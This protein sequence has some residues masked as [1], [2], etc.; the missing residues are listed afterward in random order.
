[1]E[2]SGLECSPKGVSAP[3]GRWR[4]SMLVFYYETTV[5]RPE[6]RV[7][8]EGAV[9]LVWDDAGW[10]L[11]RA[12]CV[13]WHGFRHD[14]TQGWLAPQA[15]W[16][17]RTPKTIRGLSVARGVE[18]LSGFRDMGVGSQSAYCDGAAQKKAGADEPPVQWTNHAFPGGN[19]RARKPSG[20][21][22]HCTI[23]RRGRNGWGGDGVLGG[24][25]PWR[26]RTSN[27]MRPEAAGRLVSSKAGAG[28]GACGERES[29]AGP[30]ASWPIRRCASASKCLLPLWAAAWPSAQGMTESRQGGCGVGA[31]EVSGP[32]FSGRRMGH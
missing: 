25:R 5:R 18:R 10:F 12:P 17:G 8:S 20:A 9:G 6:H 19:A 21:I 29:H 2:G 7:D 15:R 1:M 27:L 32:A 22:H 16:R 4:R 3:R 23:R 14:A 31:A 28:A 11:Q 13:R 24:H 26:A 30:R